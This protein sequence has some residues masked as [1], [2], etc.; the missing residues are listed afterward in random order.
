MADKTYPIGYLEKETKS[1]DNSL[2]VKNL[3]LTNEQVVNLLLN[4]TLELTGLG[5][6]YDADI[7]VVINKAETSDFR[8]ATVNKIAK[9]K[10]SSVTTFTGIVE[11]SGSYMYVELLFDDGGSCTISYKKII[12]KGHTVKFPSSAMPRIGYAISF[13]GTVQEINSKTNIYENVNILVFDYDQT[14]ENGGYI[15]DTTKIVPLYQ[16]GE[17]FL[18]Y[19]TTDVTFVLRP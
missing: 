13:D 15:F 19:L 18:L 5:D 7:I 17:H 2:I 10:N 12:Q 1:V 14:S 4:G 9:M 11:S 16:N 6:T 8:L 3:Y